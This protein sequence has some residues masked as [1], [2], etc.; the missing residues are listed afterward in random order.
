MSRG[1]P[2]WESLSLWRLLLRCPLRHS[3]HMD[4]ITGHLWRP[5]LV[6]GMALAW[7]G[8]EPPLEWVVSSGSPDA[9]GTCEEGEDAWIR[10]GYYWKEQR[11]E[12][13]WATEMSISNGDRWSYVKYSLPKIKNKRN[14]ERDVYFVV[15]E[16]FSWETLQSC[17]SNSWCIFN[18]FA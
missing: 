11:N 8:T 13:S 18:L 14:V 12:C 7:D 4:R 9:H 3:A 6:L 17:F 15:L 2:L 10:S 16:L 1:A 5:W